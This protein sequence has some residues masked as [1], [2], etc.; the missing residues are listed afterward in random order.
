MVWETT[1]TGVGRRTLIPESDGIT[2]LR[3]QEE[4]VI[5]GPRRTPT[6][7]VDLSP[8]DPTTGSEG[9]EEGPNG[10]GT[11]KDGRLTDLYSFILEDT[12]CLR[13]GKNGRFRS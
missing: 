10:D 9:K 12:P 5:R 3:K 6:P 7:R 1:D 2:V 8:G 4:L 11:R 13:G